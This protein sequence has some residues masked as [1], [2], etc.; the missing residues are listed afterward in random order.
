MQMI[1]TVLSRLV[2][3]HAIEAQWIKACNSKKSARSVAH[4]HQ[5]VL[6]D[7]FSKHTMFKFL[8]P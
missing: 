2:L 1:I 3:P 5:G 8:P 6:I 4:D 7:S